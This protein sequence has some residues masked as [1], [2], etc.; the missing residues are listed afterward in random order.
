MVTLTLLV[1][2]TNTLE[3][4]QKTTLE[5]GL[6]STEVAKR[7]NKSRATIL[8]WCKAGVFPN[9][10]KSGPYKQSDW[11]IPEADVQAF[12]EKQTRR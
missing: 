2:M 5:E 9:S 12:I 7:L 10:Y 11:R 6:P 8:R 4:E 1:I 3:M